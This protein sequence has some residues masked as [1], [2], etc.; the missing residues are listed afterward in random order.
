M[1]IREGVTFQD[2]TPLDAEA[3]RASLQYYKDAG[4]R[5]DLDPVV[6]IVVEDPMTVV[7]QLD[8]PYAILPSLLAD[9]AGMIISPAAIAADPEAIADNPVGTGPFQLTSWT[10]D[11]E[12]EFAAN[13]NYWK[14]APPIG[15]LQI[16]LFEE[17]GSMV[18]AL[19]TGQLDYAYPV[20]SRQLPVL[21]AAGMKAGWTDTLQFRFLRLNQMTPPLDNKL[22][23]QAINI[24][25]DREAIALALLGDSNPTVPAHLPFPPGYWAYG[26]GTYEYPY[27]PEQAK[28]LLAEAGFPDGVTVDVCPSSSTPDALSEIQI[29]EEQLR[30]SNITL[31]VVQVPGTGCLDQFYEGEWPLM[32]TGHTG[33]ADPWFTYSE[34]WAS[35]GANNMNNGEPIHPRIDEALLEIAGSSD[36]ADQTALYEEIHELWL[37]EAP[38]VGLYY[39]PRITAMAANVDGELIDLQGKIYLANLYFTS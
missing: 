20:G 38:M 22:V 12:F 17:E 19:T 24:G 33:R 25:I 29:L 10:K 5:T 13:Q 4:V 39:R 6:D 37:E 32:L 21:D 16:R 31:N 35:W 27:D 18:S 8:Q 26:D 9:R 28:A 1:Q 7:L 15:G 23:R 14:G 2:G 34:A 3:V 11:V 30:A 36:I